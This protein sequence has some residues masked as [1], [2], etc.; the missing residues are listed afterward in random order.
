M[1]DSSLKADSYTGGFIYSSFKNSVK[2][3]NSL[4]VVVNRFFDI[5]SI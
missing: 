3:I 4:I 2:V 5:Y 1:G